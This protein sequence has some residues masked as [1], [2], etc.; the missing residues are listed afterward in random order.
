MIYPFPVGDTEYKFELTRDALVQIEAKGINVFN[1][2]AQ[3]ITAITGLI[4]G[5]LTKHHRISFATA[6]RIAD[7]ALTEYSITDLLDWLNEAVAGVFQSGDQQEKKR[8]I[9]KAIA[10]T[11]KETAKILPIKTEE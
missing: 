5:G 4:Y 7:T 11:A 10:E 6:G 9:P 3:P 1:I 8:Q 2:M